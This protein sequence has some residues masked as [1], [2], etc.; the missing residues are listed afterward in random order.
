MQ[1][2]QQTT[3]QTAD[4]STIIRLKIKIPPRAVTNVRGSG[5]NIDSTVK[6][7]IESINKQPNADDAI[8]LSD[9]GS[10]V[11]II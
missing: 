9:N 7:L 5:N 11:L 8:K 10:G 3:E 6:S 1:T 2:T 4:G